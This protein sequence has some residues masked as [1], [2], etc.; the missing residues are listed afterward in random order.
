MFLVKSCN[1]EKNLLN[2]NTL[3]IGTLQEYRKTEQQQILDK[4]EGFFYVTCDVNNLFIDIN[5]FN[6]INQSK[7]GFIKLIP[8]NITFKKQYKNILLIDF[9]AKYQWVNNSRFIFCLSKMK[10]HTESTSIFPNYD[11]YWYTHISNKEIL[12][13][14]IE[15]ALFDEVIKSLN[16]G[17]KVFT[18]PTP[19]INN[20]KIKSHFQEIIYT[21]RN[22]HLNNES[23]Y[24]KKEK[25]I[26]LLNGINYVKPERY[27][28]EF[29]VRIVFDFFDNDKLLIPILDSIIIPFFDTGIIEKQ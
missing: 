10:D 17:Y 26:S 16:K 19:N 14:H 24:P 2:I 7:E 20:L 23:F 5:Y 1:K 29:E 25:L 21:D 6:F 3:K 15:Q 22:I 27:N 28:T 9:K 13:K 8:E 18:K 12:I 11:D 4:E